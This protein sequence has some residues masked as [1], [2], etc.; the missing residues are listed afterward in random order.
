MRHGLGI[1]WLRLHKRRKIEVM[2]EVKIT[3]LADVDEKDLEE[4]KRL[5]HHAEGIYREYDFLQNCS[6]NVEVLD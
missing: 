2:K 4:A 5:T 6:V 1:S 3:I